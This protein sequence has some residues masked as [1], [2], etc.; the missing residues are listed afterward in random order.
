MKDTWRIMDRRGLD[1]E[2]KVMERSHVGS[3]R[4]N[5]LAS[6]SENNTL[7]TE[8]TKEM[9]RIGETKRTLVSGIYE[10]HG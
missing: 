9:R 10:I 7:K 5:R 1:T 8:M 2:G 3:E 6:R 4:K